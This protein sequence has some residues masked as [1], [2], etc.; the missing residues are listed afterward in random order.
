MSAVPALKLVAGLS[1]CCA[2]AR[3]F[4]FFITRSRKLQLGGLS[5]PPRRKVAVMTRGE[6]FVLFVLLIALTNADLLLESGEIN[7]NV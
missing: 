5:D 3:V 7:R 1:S 4:C 2:C 6:M